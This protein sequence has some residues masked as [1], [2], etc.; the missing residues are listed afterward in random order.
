V[1]RLTARL[2]GLTGRIH[3]DAATWERAAVV[4]PEELAGAYRD[5]LTGLGVTS[6]RRDGVAV[7]PAAALLAHFPVALLERVAAPGPAR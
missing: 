2:G 7:L 6:E 3:L 1:P 5:R 4:L